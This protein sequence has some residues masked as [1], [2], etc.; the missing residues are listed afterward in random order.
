MGL[1]PP[2]HPYVLLHVAPLVD[3]ALDNG[4]RTLAVAVSV[5]YVIRCTTVAPSPP[6]NHP[7][8][9]V[10]V[11][12]VRLYL[13]E[14]NDPLVLAVSVSVAY[15]IRFTMDVPSEVGGLY[16]PPNHP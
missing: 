11:T 4:P 14:L 10:S 2:I 8:V 15:V 13:A 5:A 12:A 1:P 3:L 16:P 6:A 9:V 7:Y